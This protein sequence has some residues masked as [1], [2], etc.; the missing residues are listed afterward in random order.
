MAKKITLEQ[1]EKP[2]ANGS[3]LSDDVLNQLFQRYF[4]CYLDSKHAK[5]VFPRYSEKLPRRKGEA[6]Q[7]MTK[8]SFVETVKLICKNHHKL[9]I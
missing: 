3:L 8:Q 1:I 2:E 5:K 7:M 6:V 4:D 9:I